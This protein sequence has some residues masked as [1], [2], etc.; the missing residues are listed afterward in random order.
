MNLI[1]YIVKCQ[2]LQQFRESLYETE[3]KYYPEF[4]N[5]SREK[6]DSSS[7]NKQCFNAT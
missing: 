4:N 7:N 1:Y 5:L 6:N 3:Q 2:S